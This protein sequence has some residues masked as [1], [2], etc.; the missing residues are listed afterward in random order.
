[1]QDSPP[2]NDCSPISVDPRSKYHSRLSNRATFV[3]NK[4]STWSVKLSEYARSCNKNIFDGEPFHQNFT[5]Y[6]YLHKPCPKKINL[7][8]F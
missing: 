2:A 6:T 3:N 1:M 5:V 4:Y 8:C 7:Y